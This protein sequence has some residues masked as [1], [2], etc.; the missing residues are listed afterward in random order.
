MLESP[1]AN[2]IEH[3]VH[4]NTSD[5]CIIHFYTLIKLFPSKNWFLI[6]VLILC[7]VHSLEDFQTFPVAF[8][9]TIKARLQ[10][11]SRIL[12]LCAKPA[13]NVG[14]H[15]T[16]VNINVGH[17]KSCTEVVNWWF[18]IKAAH[19][20]SDNQC[21]EMWQQSVPEP[22]NITQWLHDTRI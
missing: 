21:S 22:K 4:I 6:L 5:R 10:N 14:E 15:I 1:Y 7:V 17:I 13:Y 16:W 8:I 3:R 18:P 11:S 9:G 20:N 2:H 12:L 19:F